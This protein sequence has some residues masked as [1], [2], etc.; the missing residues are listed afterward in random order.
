MS[1]TTA[2][3]TTAAAAT[4]A[5][6][7]TTSLN[8]L[9]IG[10]GIAGPVLAMTLLRLGHTVTI[11]ERGVSGGDSYRGAWITFQ[12]NGM[13]ALR[14]IDASGTIEEIGY[15]LDTISFVNGAGKSLGA[16]PMAAPREDGTK[17]RIMRRSDL[18]VA[19][20]REAASRGARVEYEKEL[21]D[22]TT[23]PDG[24]VKA[25]FKDGTSAIGDLLVGA[26]GIH[27]RVRTLID[28]DAQ[29][30]RYVP[31]LNTG[32][33]IPNF[34]LHTAPETMT[35]QFGTR[36]FFGWCATPDGGAVWFANPPLADEPARGI[37]SSKSDADWR[38][39]LHELHDGDAGPAG[40]LIDA[41][42][43]P[44]S[45]WATYDLPAVRKW[46]NG[47]MVIIGDAAHA[48]SPSSGQGASMAIEDAVI[49]GKCLRDCPSTRSALDTFVSLRKERVEKI[50]AYGARSANSKAAGPVARVFRDLLLPWVF[51]YA[52]RD[53]GKGMQWLQG[54]HIDWDDKVVPVE[55]G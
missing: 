45:G 48:T 34:P 22:A 14:A 7:P 38:A 37:L 8:V 51:W 31:V 20:A 15:V 19:L 30:P 49:L 21:V 9:I 18:F 5:P 36:C 52:A 55:S 42:V 53:G 44:L 33:Y 25:V 13:D 26:D 11:Y 24:R 54:Y 43:G 39:W 32:G 6:A 3:S 23:L 12:A 1:T 4:A 16:M 28:P 50:V 35:M 2:T 40:A 10:S 27:S 41:A 47:A 17:S 29:K 46:H